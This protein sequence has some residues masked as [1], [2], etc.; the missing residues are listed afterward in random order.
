MGI[1]V[2]CITAAIYPSFIEFNSYMLYPQV[3][4]GQYSTSHALTNTNTTI[5]YIFIIISFFKTL[6]FY[7]YTNNILI[8]LNGLYLGLVVNLIIYS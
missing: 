8:Y 7:N 3:T 5:I 2:H 4:A 6:T 1:K